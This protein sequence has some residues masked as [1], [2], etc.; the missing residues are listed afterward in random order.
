MGDHGR[1]IDTVHKCRF[2]VYGFLPT[3]DFMFVGVWSAFIV[4]YP[5]SDTEKHGQ[6]HCRIVRIAIGLWP[7]TVLESDSKYNY[8]SCDGKF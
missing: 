6:N 1:I 4:F 5:R 7:F 8:L 2:D 3:D